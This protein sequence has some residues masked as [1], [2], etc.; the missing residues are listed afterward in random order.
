VTISVLGD[1]EGRDVIDVE[2]LRSD[3]EKVFRELDEGTK[4]T[5]FSNILSVIRMLYDKFVEEGCKEMMEFYD[6]LLKSCK[7]GW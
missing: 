1:K 4:T 2:R 3:L 5:I 6:D 7:K